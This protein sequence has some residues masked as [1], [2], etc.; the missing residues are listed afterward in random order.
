MGHSLEL[1]RRRFWREICGE[2]AKAEVVRG[3]LGE[4][5]VA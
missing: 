2:Q 3:L 5:Q 1:D 4:G